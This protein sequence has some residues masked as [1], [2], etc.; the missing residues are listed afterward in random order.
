MAQ[1]G[2]EGCFPVVTTP[3]PSLHWYQVTNFLGFDDGS[4]WA[5]YAAGRNSSTE[6]GLPRWDGE[7]WTWVGGDF[8]TVVALAVFDDGTGKALYGGGEVFVGPALPLAHVVRWDGQQWQ[9]LPSTVNGFVSVLATFN[10]GTGEALYVGGNF[11]MAGSVPA[12]HIARWD[13][14][15]WSSLGGGVNNS[16]WAMA[17]Y[18]DAA[19]PALYV[20]G[21]FTQAGGAPAAHIARWDG[22]G[23]WSPLGDGMNWNVAPIAVFED[24]SGMALYAAGWFSQ[25]VPYLARWD[26]ASWSAVGTQV[27]RQPFGLA[28]F[29][30]GDGPHLYAVG[31]FTDIGGV[32]FP[33][34]ARWDGATWSAIGDLTSDYPGLTVAATDDGAPAVYIAF[35]HN[36]WHSNFIRFGCEPQL[37][38]CYAN[39]DGSTVAPNLNIDDFICFVNEFAQAQAVPPSQQMTHYANCDGS[40]I[41]PILSVND[42]LC[43]INEFAAGCP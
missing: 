6:L 10:D 20:S 34:A 17:R 19:G 26:G 11:N 38:P 5:L 13:G 41:E 24:A 29:D 16:V 31:W 30:V 25:P 39:C 27:N 22:A 1:G 9:P 43:F 42:F 14:Q 37:P 21:R 3:M 4:G 2:A 36:F 33:Y 15:N 8:G 35:Y 18:E 28:S 12:S 7:L 40:T 32:P 23:G